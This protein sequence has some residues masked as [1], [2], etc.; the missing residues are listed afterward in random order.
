M[1]RT[2]LLSVSDVS[3]ML[4]VHE[5]TVRRFIRSGKLPVV[6]VGR[7]IRIRPEDVDRLIEDPRMRA[8]P[9]CERPNLWTVKA[10]GTCGAPLQGNGATP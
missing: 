5:D 10:C 4:G 9:V 3:R 2:F 1:I 8:C 6:W 7:H